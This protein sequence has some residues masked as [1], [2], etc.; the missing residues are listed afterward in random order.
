MSH[1]FEGVEMQPDY[2]QD[3]M[4]NLQAIWGRPVA[5]ATVMDGEPKIVTFDGTDF[6]HQTLSG[7]SGGE[8]GGGSGSSGTP[9]E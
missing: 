4:R 8:K 3:T 1:L 7:L 6:K 5:V 9:S 2:M